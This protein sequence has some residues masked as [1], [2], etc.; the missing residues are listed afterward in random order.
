MKK[1]DLEYIKN[2]LTY[3]RDNTDLTSKDQFN[4]SITDSLNLID[5]EINS[6]TIDKDCK[7]FDILEEAGSILYSGSTQYKFLP[8]WFEFNE[9]REEVLMHHLDKIPDELK[10]RL[11]ED[12]NFCKSLK[13]K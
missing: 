3:L 8:F 6:N 1:Q 10:N 11:N 5:K 13:R 12:R 9:N 2:T 7:L 4:N